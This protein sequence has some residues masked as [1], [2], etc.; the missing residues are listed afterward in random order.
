MK[1]V[2][3]LLVAGSVMLACN[4]KKEDSKT[5]TK[6]EEKTTTAPDT[7]TNVPPPVTTTNDNTSTITSGWSTSDENRFMRDC[8]STATPKVGAER[9]NVYCDCML[10]K[11]K[12]LYNSYMEA[13]RGL[14]N[15]EAAM[16]R[17]AADCNAQQ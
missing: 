11:I 4:N 13:D 3:L 10:Q 5:E 6:T 15:D 7:S 16:N 9:A 8:E 14:A 17:L 2:L 1:K 12:G